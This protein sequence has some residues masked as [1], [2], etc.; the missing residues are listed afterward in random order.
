MN[1]EQCQSTHPKYIEEHRSLQLFL[2]HGKANEMGS[3][4]LRAWEHICELF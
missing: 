2:A 1:L 3:E 4:Q